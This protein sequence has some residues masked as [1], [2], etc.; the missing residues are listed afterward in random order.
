MSKRVALPR[1]P[2]PPKN[3]EKHQHD[4]KVC[5]E[6]GRRKYTGPGSGVRPT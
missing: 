5:S 4:P 3:D 2:E 1:P 6:C